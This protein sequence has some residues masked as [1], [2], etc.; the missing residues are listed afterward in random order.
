MR[1]YDKGI[2]GMTVYRDGTRDVQ[3]MQTNQENTL[4]D[5]DTVVDAIA[6]LVDNE[7]GIEEFLT[8]DEFMSV[9]GLSNSEGVVIKQDGEQVEASVVSAEE[10]EES[11]DK[12]LDNEATQENVEAERRKRRTHIHGQRRSPYTAKDNSRNNPGNRDSLR[13]PVCNNQRRR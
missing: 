5:M 2:K 13:R 9:A 10:L 1:A 12:E 8:S 6:E 4:T 11:E 7:G 3:V